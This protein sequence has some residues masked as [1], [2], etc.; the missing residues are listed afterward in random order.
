MRDRVAVFGLLGLALG[1]CKDEGSAAVSDTAGLPSCD[2]LETAERYL[3][4]TLVFGPESDGVAWGFDLD[5]HV[6]GVGDLEGCGK[7]DL[8]D[9]EGNA[10]I[11]NAFAGLLPTLEQTEAIAVETLIQDAVNSGNLLLALELSGVDDRLNDDCVTVRLGRA[12]GVPLLGNDGLLLDGQTLAWEPD[13]LGPPIEAALIDG[14]LVASPFTVDIDLRV[15]TADVKLSLLDSG[16][17]LQLDEDA[18][19]ATGFVSGGFQTAQLLDVLSD[20]AI[21][22]ELRAILEQG[23]PLLADLVDPETGACDLMSVTLEYDAVEVYLED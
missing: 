9:P 15:I 5:G 13:S 2:S 1:S 17:R 16:L 7:Q 21:D 8:V 18:P 20:Q 3:V 19:R 22:V 6:S 23:L 12:E 10:G 4:R 11:D 14:Q